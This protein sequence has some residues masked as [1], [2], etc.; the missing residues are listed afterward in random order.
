MKSRNI[1]IYYLLSIVHNA[2]FV[3]GNWIFFFTRFMTYKT[4]G[5]IEAVALGF[6]FIMEI[7]AGILADYIGKK[8]TLQL[9]MLSGVIGVFLFTIA[10]N[11]FTILIGY[12]FSQ[13]GWALYSGTSE[14][15]AY[16]TLKAEGRE[17]EYSHVIAKS[18][19]IGVITFVIASLIG[20]ILYTLHFRLPNSVWLLFVLG[21]FIFTFFLKEPLLDI[22]RSK[23]IFTYLTSGLK[24]LFRPQLR[25]YILIILL[26][27]GVNYSYDM[28]FIK[29]LLALHFG[30][31]DKAQSVI[32]ALS[33][34]IVF[35]TIRLLPC[36][37]KKISD[38]AGLRLLLFLFG[39]SFVAASFPLHFFGIIVLFVIDIFGSVATPWISIVVN[40]EVSSKYRA[41]TLSSVAFITKIP[42]VITA[43]IFG[44]LF[45]NGKVFLF[46]LGIS[47][48]IFF[49][50]LINGLQF[51]EKKRE[52]D[53]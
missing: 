11:A 23:G 29:P 32:F 22:K 45:E 4:F 27:L 15:L 38:K 26:L 51:L 52:G 44:S 36:I 7:P 39:C 43:F 13:L 40:K 21:G 49:S 46:T 34:L 17:G 25:S 14:A 19:S 47:C 12:M 20:G 1:S 35:F 8:R 42:Y 10:H 18:T 16:D 24:E 28:G 50:L 33:G 2:W 30:F 9:S 3:E 31:L 6:G 5:V 37:R 41:T 48:I 53:F